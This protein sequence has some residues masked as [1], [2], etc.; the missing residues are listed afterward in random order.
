MFGNNDDDNNT[1]NQQ[2]IEVPGAPPRVRAPE[3][4][5]PGFGAY[6]RS[7]AND[8]EDAVA[9]N[10]GDQGQVQADGAYTPAAAPVTVNPPIILRPIPI[11]RTNSMTSA[12]GDNNLATN[13]LDAF[14]AVATSTA[15][16]LAVASVV[17]VGALAHHDAMS[18]SGHH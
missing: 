5:Q 13:L 12:E 14:D 3:R 11:S 2:P 10:G 16:E 17:V 8:L 15:V 4:Q 6:P 9:V 7:L 18:G 1:S